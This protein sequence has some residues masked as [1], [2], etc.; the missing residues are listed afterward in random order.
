KTPDF[1]GQYEKLQHDWPE[2]VK[3]KK[4]EQ[5][6]EMSKNKKN[7]AKKEYNH[8]MGPGGYRFWQ[9][10]WEKMENEAEGEESVQATRLESVKRQLIRAKKFI[11]FPVRGA[12]ANKSTLRWWRRRWWWWLTYTSG[13]P[14]TPSPPIHRGCSAQS[15]VSAR[16]PA[17]SRRWTTP[18]A[19]H[20]PLPT[21]SYPP[22]PSPNPSSGA[23]GGNA[24]AAAR[25]LFVPLRGAL[26]A[27]AAAAQMAAAQGDGNMRPAPRRGKAPSTKRSYIGA[28]SVAPPK[29]TKAPASR[30]PQPPPP[31]TNQTSPP[32]PPTTNQPTPT[33][34]NRAGAHTVHDEMPE[35]VDDATFMETMNVG[36]SFMHDEAADGEEEYEDVDEEGEGLIEPRHPGNEEKW[37]TRGKLDAATMAANATGDATIIDDDDS[38]DEGKKRS[39]V[40]GRKTA[41][42]MKGKKAGDDDIAMAMERI[43]NARLQANEDR[44]MQRNLEKEAMD[45]IEARR[46]AL[47]ERIAANEERKL[48]LEEKRQATEEHLRLAEEEGSFLDGYFPNE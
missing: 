28:A 40:H 7:A 33:S 24:T 23:D 6:L 21:P 14:P 13:G 22:P 25:A 32:P 31:P 4:S 44:K 39:C 11:K 1:K 27:G 45:A 47:E 10:R 26:H 29:K 46:A 42:D 43:A 30:R 3:Q 37:K 19:T 18:P 5:F 35:R 20:R 17:Q 12:K 16:P 36:S 9:P 48:A 38:S 2:F 15:V 41:K 34:G 8:I